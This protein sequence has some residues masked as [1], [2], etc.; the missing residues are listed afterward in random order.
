MKR[1][2]MAIVLCAA[3]SAGVFTGCAEATTNSAAASNA[4]FST[5]MTL[6]S[7][8]A[9]SQ[10]SMTGNSTQTVAGTGAWSL[11]TSDIFSDR[12]MEQTAD[13]SNAKTITLADSQDV[14]ISEEGVYVISGTAK[15]AT[16]TV[17]ADDSAKVQIVLDGANITN[18]DKPAIYVKSA[19]KAFVTTAS[20]SSNTLEVT[21]EFASSTDSESNVDGVIY[22]K[23]DITLNGQGTLIVSST[24][25][26]IVGKD[27]VKMTGGSYKINASNHA[28]QGKDSV[29]IAGGTFDLTAGK[30]GIHAENSDDQ[31]LGYVYVK[32]GKFTIKADSDGIAG[33]AAVQ[34]DGGTFAINSG[35]GIEGTF[36][37]INDGTVDIDATD[38]GI[39]ATTK[40]STYTVAIEINGGNVTIDMGEGDTDALDANGNLTI[41]GGTV[42]INA[43]FAF[44]FDGQGALNGG[45]VTVNGEQV[46]EITNS[47]MMGGM[48]GGMGGQGGMPQGGMGGQQGGPQ[49]GMGGQR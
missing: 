48:G 15:N 25:N 30:D 1:I 34:I 11:D 42:A 27:D 9:P 37:Q 22:S 41:N 20:G 45:T 24:A 44:D 47:M 35:E 31:S 32:D 8:E 12:D 38:D 6:P 23:D 36:V 28:I 26:G 19:D 5:E 4:S 43:Q 2:G 13:T 18:S 14:T 39:N 10:G 46:T 3:L 29:A 40:S 49:G 21:G 33:Y 7:G 16:I 17:E